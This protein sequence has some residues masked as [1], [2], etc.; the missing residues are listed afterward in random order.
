MA[1]VVF[2]RGGNVG[3]HRNFRPTEVARRLS[4]FGAINVG[5]AGTFVIPARV[6]STVL[7]SALSR[8]LPFECNIAICDGRD[9]IDLVSAAAPREAAERGAVRFASVL[10]RRPRALPALPIVL[11]G[12]GRWLVKI[13][14]C[15]GRFVVGVYRRHMKV[16]GYL[17]AID[18]LVGVPVT[19]R[20]WGTMTAVA[21]TL[22]A[23]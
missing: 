20:S 2:L 15:D 18:R 11:P 13:L 1:L 16:I 9:I 23:R 14:A 7:R 6:G 10:T 19:T 12:R 17:G 5:A 4:R 8:C 3:G 22:S 21:R